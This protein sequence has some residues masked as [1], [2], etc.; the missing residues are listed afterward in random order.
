[1]EALLLAFIFVVFF[2]TG[3]AVGFLLASKSKKDWGQAV[4]DAAATVV[5]RTI[6]KPAFFEPL[7]SE[8]EEALKRE[9]EG[10]GPFEKS[11]EAR[12]EEE[13]KNI[14]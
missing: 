10:W 5:N 8:K 14:Q 11:I 12:A 9:D 2:L 4:E 6:R 3:I 1:M 7:D 13:V